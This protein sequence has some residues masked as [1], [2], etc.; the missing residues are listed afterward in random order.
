MVSPKRKCFHSDGEIFIT[1]MRW[2]LRG[3]SRVSKR[4]W[5]LKAG[6]WS[7]SA[8]H[9]GTKYVR[10]L[11]SGVCEPVV[12]AGI[13]GMAATRMTESIEVRVLDGLGRAGFVGCVAPRPV[14]CREQ[15]PSSRGKRFV[16]AISRVI[17]AV[18]PDCGNPS[19]D[20]PTM[21]GAGGRMEA[22][23][24]LTSRVHFHE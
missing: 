18:P 23:L 10:L 2:D 1:T 5:F 17:A 16:W 15:G 11:A 9:E 14:V 7:S 22:W 24:L 21:T 20:A 6:C 8:V 4:D 3:S 19:F 13:V 12:F